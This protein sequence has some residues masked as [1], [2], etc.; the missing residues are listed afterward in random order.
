MSSE[1]YDLFY[2]STGKSANKETNNI[3]IDCPVFNECLNHALKYEEYGYWASTT[4]LQRKAI[5][6]KEGIELID[7]SSE[8]F[9]KYKEDL[10]KQKE[11]TQLLTSRRGPKISRN[12]NNSLQAKPD[13][14]YNNDSLITKEWGS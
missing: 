10:Q 13:S 7:I 1:N 2:V 14:D 3:C 8:S 12:T 6:K 11:F 9:A 4:P 5:R